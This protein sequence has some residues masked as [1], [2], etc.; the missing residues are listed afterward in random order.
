[1]KNKSKSENIPSA[2][3][4]KKKYESIK[5]FESIA[6]NVIYIFKYMLGKESKEELIKIKSVFASISEKGR[7]LGEELT[8]LGIPTSKPNP[9][10]R[11][12]PTLIK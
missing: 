2:E 10:K 5:E 11:A 8:R 7:V 9:A 3:E 6:P 4:I 12:T 1:M